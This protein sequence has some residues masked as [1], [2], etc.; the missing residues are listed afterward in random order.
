MWRA[1][2]LLI[3]IISRTSQ[4]NGVDDRR[5]GYIARGSCSAIL[6]QSHLLFIKLY[7]ID[8]FKNPLINEDPVPI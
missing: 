6:I 2:F 1:F 4:P 3:L 7:E 5:E 8:I